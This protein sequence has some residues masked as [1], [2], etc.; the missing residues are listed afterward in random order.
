MLDCILSLHETLGSISG[1][2]NKT[3]TRIWIHCISLSTF[4]L[5]IFFT[6]AHVCCFFSVPCHKFFLLFMCV[7][8]Y[9]LCACLCGAGDWIQSLFMCVFW[10][11]SKYGN[12]SLYAHF[13]TDAKCQEQT[14]A[15]SYMC[16]DMY[17]WESHHMS[18][19]IYVYMCVIWVDTYLVNVL[20]CMPL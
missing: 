18:E 13:Y 19:H 6:L 5:G 11:M 10:Y 14:Y 9:S 12:I 17:F 15:G 3:K 16:I 8:V 7:P 20:P 4:F 2:T 1:M